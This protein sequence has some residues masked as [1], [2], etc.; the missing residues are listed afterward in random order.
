ME[1]QL[2][3]KVSA[4]VLI[5][6]AIGEKIPAKLK[7]VWDRVFG[8]KKI[9]S[10]LNREIGGCLGDFTG[11]ELEGEEITL[12]D[13][14]SCSNIPYGDKEKYFTGSVIVKDLPCGA[15]GLNGLPT[16]DKCKFLFYL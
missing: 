12:L 1:A 9:L 6:H 15:P 16:Q 3:L 10:F 8:E 7:P 4:R 2:V 5:L 14:T 13:E 11:E